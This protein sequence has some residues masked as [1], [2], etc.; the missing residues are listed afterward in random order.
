MFVIPN[1]VQ[2]KKRLSLSMRSFLSA[3]SVREHVCN[4]NDRALSGSIVDTFFLYIDS[5][6][7]IF[8]IPN[9]L[10]PNIDCFCRCAAPCPL[11]AYESMYVTKSIERCSAL[12]SIFLY[13]YRYV[14]INVAIV[15]DFFLIQY[16]IFKIPDDV[17]FKR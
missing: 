17:F 6:V 2:P 7:S 14:C 3:A 1:A 16:R 4:E 12:S 8:V 11:L 10:Q 5:Y 13:V 15:A 9:A